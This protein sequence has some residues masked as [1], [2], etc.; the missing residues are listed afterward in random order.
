MKKSRTLSRGDIWRI[1]KIIDK[2]VRL[3]CVERYNNRPSARRQTVAAH[4]YGVTA[5]FAVLYEYLSRNDRVKIDFK[6]GILTSLFHDIDEV[7]FGD[8]I[9]ISKNIIGKRYFDVVKSYKEDLFEDWS[10]KPVDE[11]G[12]SDPTLML[13]KICDLLEGALYS[14][15]QYSLYGNKLYEKIVSSFIARLSAVCEEF[16]YLFKTNLTSHVFEILDKVRDSIEMEVE[17]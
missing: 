8:I 9:S 10:Y 11:P 16:D 7:D 17:L 5:I 1:S 6:K 3:D 13:V 15:V 12:G 4:S 2:V 14:I